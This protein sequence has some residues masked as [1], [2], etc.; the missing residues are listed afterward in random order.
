MD[1]ESISSPEKLRSDGEAANPPPGDVSGKDTDDSVES[2]SSERWRDLMKTVNPNKVTKNKSNFILHTRRYKPQGQYVHPYPHFYYDGDN[3][4]R[5]TT[6]Y[7]AEE[8]IKRF[9]R[10]GMA[11][12]LIKLSPG[13]KYSRQLPIPSPPNTEANR[14]IKD[15][16]TSTQSSTPTA[17]QSEDNV[18]SELNDIE[19]CNDDDGYD[20]DSD[21]TDAASQLYNFSSPLKTN[22]DVGVNAVVKLHDAATSP[23]KIINKKKDAATSPIK[24]ILFKVMPENKKKDAATSPMKAI[25]FK[26]DGKLQD[27]TTSPNTSYN[28]NKT[29]EG[30]VLALC[31]E[32]IYGMV[33]Q[34]GYTVLESQTVEKR[35]DPSGKTC[36]KICLI[37]EPDNNM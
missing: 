2:V 14:R 6:Y 24:K 37:V 22:E 28:N 12:Y 32:R 13:K 29:D 17:T 30:S 21:V 36:I 31:A 9:K 5:R 27:A 4:L 23:I 3:Q 34:P 26:D 35:L 8:Q 1:F 10:T 16:F 25:S 18:I 7:V 15:W 11:P 19:E 20:V 33:T